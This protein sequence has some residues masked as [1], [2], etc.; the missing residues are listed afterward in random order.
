MRQTATGTN[1]ELDIRLYGEG[2]LRFIADYPGILEFYDNTVPTGPT[3]AARAKAIESVQ[4]YERPG[5]V[6]PRQ[7]GHRRLRAH[8]HSLY[9]FLTACIQ[10]QLRLLPDGVYSQYVLDMAKVAETGAW[11]R[12]KV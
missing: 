10:A 9:A 2:A 12:C 1:D 6:M 4:R 11:L 8:V 7:A 3:A 5:G